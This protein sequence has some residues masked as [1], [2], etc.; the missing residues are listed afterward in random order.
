V[1]SATWSWYREHG[2]QNIVKRAEI[3]PG[4]IRIEYRQWLGRS[5]ALVYHPGAVDPQDL[6]NR[7]VGL[8]P[9]SVP[10]QWRLAFVYVDIADAGKGA[11]ASK[12]AHR[13]RRG[14]IAALP[15]I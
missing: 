6:L 7:R 10:T 4:R 5:S 8:I 11:M 2:R 13:R 1:D 12:V 14:A 15:R 3:T 9:G